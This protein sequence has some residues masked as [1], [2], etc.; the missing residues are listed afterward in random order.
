MGKISAAGGILIAAGEVEEA[1]RRPR[2]GGGERGCGSETKTPRTFCLRL[3]LSVERFSMV[4]LFTA[5][6][7][8]HLTRSPPPPFLHRV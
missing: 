7:S 3:V 6:R 5:T 1:D 4:S 2:R 8:R